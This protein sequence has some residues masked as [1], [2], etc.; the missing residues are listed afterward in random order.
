MLSALRRRATHSR[1][2]V[3][4]RSRETTTSVRPV[5][6]SVHLLKYQL[7]FALVIMMFS[8]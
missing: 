2:I 5:V 6:V 3:P 4:R 1:W 8:P 7:Q